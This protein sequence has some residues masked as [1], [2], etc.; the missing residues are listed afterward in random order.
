[1]TTAGGAGLILSE[2][3]AALYG[4]GPDPEEA[5]EKAIKAVEEAGIPVVAPNDSRATLGKVISALRGQGDWALS[6]VDKDG[7]HQYS[8]V[9]DMCAGLWEGQPS[10][11]GANGY[12]KPSHQEA[13]AAVLLAVPLVEWFSSGQIARRV[14]PTEP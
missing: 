8:L 10:R 5:Y 9:A 4:R 14:S 2:A 13:E 7:T 11:H 12:C 3:W 1:M 6:V